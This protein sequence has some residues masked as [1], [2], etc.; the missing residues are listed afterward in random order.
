M[1]NYIIIKIFNAWHLLICYNIY[2]IFLYLR[3]FYIFFYN[4]QYLR[5]KTI[6]FMQCKTDMPS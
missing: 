3:K 5:Y 6:E 2:K 1:N 4:K